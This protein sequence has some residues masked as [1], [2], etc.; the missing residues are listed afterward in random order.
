MFST[1]DLKEKYK[2]YNDE[3]LLE[4]HSTNADYSNEANAAL[5]EVIEERGGMEA[6]L[7]RLEQK[8]IIPNEIKRITKEINSLGSSTSDVHFLKTL[9][10]SDILTEAELNK[11]I[12]E[13][14]ALYDAN[15]KDITVTSKTI[16]VGSVSA[17]LSGLVVGG[18][19]GLFL[20]YMK[21]FHVLIIGGIFFL[22][23]GIIKIITK[24]SK[25]NSAIL[26]LSIVATIV[27][28]LIGFGMVRVFGNIE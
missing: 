19:F 2:K 5:N 21:A 6:L 24:Q 12:E 9:I 16:I 22:C 26:I 8:S 15:R 10:K 7:K 11:V 25:K 14:F 28:I 23:Y 27:A 3:E 17:I 1:K 18:L 13:K 20:M 4:I